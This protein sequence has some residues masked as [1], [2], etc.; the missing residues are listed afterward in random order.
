MADYFDPPVLV[1]DAPF[2]T[3]TIRCAMDAIEFLE[4]WPFES[5]G[6][7]HF[8][9]SEAC[10]AAYDGRCTA[11][12]ARN[13]FLAWASWAGVGAC[14]SPVIDGVERAGVVELL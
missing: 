7:L 12:A 2:G 3:R 1:N 10:C 8:C 6:R 5:R 4:E 13:A 11:N 9:A 14:A